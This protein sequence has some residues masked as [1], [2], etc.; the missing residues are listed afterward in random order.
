MT[1]AQDHR[2]G[3][4][5]LLRTPVGTFYVSPMVEDQEI[6]IPGMSVPLWEGALEVRRNSSDGELVGRMYMEELFNPSG[7]PPGSPLA[8]QMPSRGHLNGCHSVREC[9]PVAG[10]PPGYHHRLTRS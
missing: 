9:H 2:Y 4:Y 1:N 10:A 6:L 7:L 8:R 3:L 5:G